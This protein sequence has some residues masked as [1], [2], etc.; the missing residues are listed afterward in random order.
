MSYQLCIFVEVVTFDPCVCFSPFW[1]QNDEG[2]NVK[3]GVAL[4]TET[5]ESMGSRGQSSLWFLVLR[6]GTA[7]WGRLDL[8]A[9][10]TGK[11][12]KL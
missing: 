3:H 5:S 10:K 2:G 4:L 1:Y 8:E 9:I 11:F 7:D 12:G 6:L